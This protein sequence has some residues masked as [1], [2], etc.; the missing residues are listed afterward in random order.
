MA[1]HQEGQVGGIGVLVDYALVA[2]LEQPL[3][4]LVSVHRFNERWSD[5][6]RYQRPAMRD[7]VRNGLR[8]RDDELERSRFSH[9]AVPLVIPFENI[10][11]E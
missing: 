2:R 4:S 3:S 6:V 7:E 11:C 5:G 1:S 10:Y 8:P 9:L